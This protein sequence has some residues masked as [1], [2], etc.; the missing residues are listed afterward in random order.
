MELPESLKRLL[1]ETKQKDDYHPDKCEKPN[2]RCLEIAQEIEGGEVKYGY[3]CL[4]KVV[5]RLFER[6]SKP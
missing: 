4:A 2:C 6:K 3:P 5:S 1:E